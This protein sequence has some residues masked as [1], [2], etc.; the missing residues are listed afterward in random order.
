MYHTRIF[1][2]RLASEMSFERYEKK[3][4][5]I[6]KFFNPLCYYLLTNISKYYMVIY[7]VFIIKID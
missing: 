7:D 6:I 3:V 1:K 5:Y 2:L 4:L